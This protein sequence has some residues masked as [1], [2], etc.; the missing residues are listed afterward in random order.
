M[1]SI[2]Q[3]RGA[4]LEESLLSL[5]RASGYRTVATY[6]GDDCL[7]RHQAGLGVRGRGCSHQIDAVADHIVAHPFSNPQRLLV[8][9]KNY[10][11]SRTV[12]VD[13]I[14]NAVGVH[15]DVSEFI[16][17]GLAGQPARRRYHYQ[18]AVFASSRF[19]AEAQ[20]FAFAHDVYLFKLS[21]SSAFGA[22]L[23]AIDDFAASLPID[24]RNNVDGLD[25]ESLRLQLRGTLQPE[26]PGPVV[27]T[28]EYDLSGIAYAANSVGAS[29]VA[30]IARAFPILLVPQRPSVLETIYSEVEV[31][32]RIERGDQRQWTVWQNQSQL[33]TFDVPEEFFSRYVIAGA[34]DPERALAVKEQYFREIQF[35]FS[36][37]NGQSRLI[38]LRLDLA[39]LDNAR[40][41]LDL[42][43][44]PAPVA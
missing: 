1:A 17:P 43:R 25:L 12:G 24:R 16:P 3:V 39:W 15:K 31:Q 33:F 34:F 42:P 8:E 40:S 14:R 41:A 2:H 9:A 35:V 38:T 37:L 4:L 44:T 5:L 23:S 28:V 22:V 29:V 21:G 10:H 13:V 27:Q 36:A 19:S 7:C 18:Y 20:D 30:V 6:V 11:D 26:L 32:L